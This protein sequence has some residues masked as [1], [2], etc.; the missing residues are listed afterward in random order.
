MRAR[1][2]KGS[3]FERLARTIR[4]HKEGILAYIKDRL[5]NG[6]AEGINNR[7]RMIARRA[8]G[9][10]SAESLISMLFLCAGGIELDPPLPT[11]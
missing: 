7:L 1:R 8:Y 10:H 5:T 6:F 9:F 4:D 2:T 11:H 3:S